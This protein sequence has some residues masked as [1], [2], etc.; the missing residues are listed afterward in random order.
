MALNIDCIANSVVFLTSE[1]M[2]ESD[3]I[4][5]GTGRICRDVSADAVDSSV[6]IG[7]HDCCIPQNG[8]LY[9]LL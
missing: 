9:S 4:E 7:N 6:G 5:C 1:H 3:L 8:V 2:I